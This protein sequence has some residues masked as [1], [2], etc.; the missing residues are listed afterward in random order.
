M[1]PEWC[2]FFVCFFNVFWG[3][4]WWMKFM[5]LKSFF[6]ISPQGS[7]N[8]NNVFPST[9]LLR[10]LV[11]W[12]PV[13]YS[14]ITDL[15]SSHLGLRKGGKNVSAQIEIQKVKKER[16]MIRANAGVAF[17]FWDLI[18]FFCLCV[19]I[20][21]ETLLVFRMITRKSGAWVCCLCWR[22]TLRVLH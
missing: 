22:H 2:L 7:M 17:Y 21:V 18:F 13:G 14:L 4:S 3:C 8:G 10:E 6:L 1:R 16:I 19:P 15:G 12:L 11:F 9:P 5:L 20:L